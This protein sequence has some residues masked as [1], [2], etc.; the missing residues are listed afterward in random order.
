MPAVPGYPVVVNGIVI[1]IDET[2]SPQDRMFKSI[3]IFLLECGWIAIIADGVVYE[4]I[5]A[6]AGN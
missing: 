6:G 2:D 4:V 5:R 1:S 3:K